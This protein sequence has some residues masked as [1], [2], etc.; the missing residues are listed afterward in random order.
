VTLENCCR[1]FFNLPFRNGTPLACPKIPLITKPSGS[2]TIFGIA[3]HHLLITMGDH[4]SIRI[5]SHFKGFDSMKNSPPGRPQFYLLYQFKKGA[6]SPIDFFSYLI[7]Q[8]SPPLFRANCGG[9]SES[10][11]RLHKFRVCVIFRSTPRFYHPLNT[12]GVNE[13]GSHTNLQHIMNQTLFD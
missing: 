7:R 9:G 12:T 2:T 8:F 11:T 10:Y 1:I 6:S 5:A 13:H 4:I 3:Y